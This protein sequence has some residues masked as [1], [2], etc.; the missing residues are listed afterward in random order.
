MEN[1]FLKISIQ[2]DDIENRLITLYN[3]N[4]SPPIGIE[5]ITQEELSIRLSLSKATIIRWTKKGKIPSIK[6]GNSIRYNWISTINS[7]EKKSNTK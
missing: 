2:L 6:I 1:P 4:K 3:Q 5:I 7:L